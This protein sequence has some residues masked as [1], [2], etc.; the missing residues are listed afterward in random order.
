MLSLESELA[1]READ[2]ASL[3]A[4]QAY[5]EDQ[6]SLSTIQLTLLRPLPKP[7]PPDGEN[8]GFVGGLTVGWDALVG[9]VTVLLTA[10]GVLVPLLLLLL[11]AGLIAWWLL[12][13]VVRRQPAASPPA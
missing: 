8:T 2:L 5:L 10:F 11:P 12:R 3:K 6:T 9:L 7:Q 13:R 4:Q 1:R